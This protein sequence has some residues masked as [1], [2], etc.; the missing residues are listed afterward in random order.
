MPGK[1]RHFGTIRQLRSGRWQVRYHGP[2]G[3]RRTAPHTFDRKQDA[4][5]WLT[6]LEAQML[7]GDWI[8]PNAGRVSLRDYAL[9]WL[10]ERPGL[11]DRTREGYDDLLRLHILPSLGGL[12]INAVRESTVRRWR[13]ELLDS[14]V[15]GP[16]VAKAYRV[17]RAVMYT[18]VDDELIRRNP[19]RIKGAG[20]DTAPERPILSIPEVYA[21]ADA[22]GPRYRA[23]VLLGTF[24]SMR[25]GELAA[26]RR[27][28]IDLEAAIVSVSRSLAEL[29][30]GRLITK[31]PK[32]AAGV[33]RVALPE[34]LLPD[35]RW[36]LDRF[37]ASGPQGLVFVG[38][39]GG[40]LRRHG[41]RKRW[42]QALTDAGVQPV[43][44]HDLR[45]TGNTMAA[46]TGASTRELMTRMGQSSSRAA[47]IYQHATSE[48]DRLIA[49]AI[50]RQVL[51]LRQS[52]EPPL[53]DA[54]GA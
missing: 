27:A 10:R 5:A 35:L 14:G 34:V 39:Q 38:P 28:D 26:L 51:Q 44:F 48:R 43:H 12:P 13:S 30:N 3:L 17:L 18:A 32:S 52:P 47:L 11:S 21:V 25:L 36:H 2:D 6:Q 19:C 41:F 1:P 45:H 42:I 4:T 40:P 16:T 29:K 20:D 22:I 37:A 9:A 31:M 50:N 33:R 23:L 49:D 54:D 46:A 53:D 7:R 8:D 24:A 15:G